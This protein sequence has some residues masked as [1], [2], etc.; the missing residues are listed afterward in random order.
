MRKLWIYIGLALGLLA[1]PA[2]AMAQD[3]TPE[4]APRTSI[5]D[6]VFQSKVGTFIDLAT[7]NPDAADANIQL[8]FRLQLGAD[9]AVNTP[10]KDVFFVGDAAALNPEAVANL[11]SA[12]DGTTALSEAD[13]AGAQMQALFKTVT[14]TDKAADA[15]ERTQT[16]IPSSFL[17]KEEAGFMFLGKS[18]PGFAVSA[19]GGLLF[20]DGGTTDAAG[21]PTLNCPE[22]NDWIKYDKECLAVRPTKVVK[23][24][25]QSSIATPLKGDNAPVI[26][27]AGTDDIGF[28]IWAQFDYKIDGA[29]WLFQIRYYENGHIDYIVG[30][31][32]GKSA[33]TATAD[34]HFGPMAV[35]GTR[36][37]GVIVG[38][39]FPAENAHCWDALRKHSSITYTYQA[40]KI[41]T[42]CGPETG[43]TISVFPPVS[44]AAFSLPGEPTMGVTSLEGKIRLDPSQTSASSLEGVHTFCISM[45]TVQNLGLGSYDFPQTSAPTP[46]FKNDKTSLIYVGKP[47]DM[48][49][50]FEM[51]LTTNGLKPNTSYY[52]YVYSAYYAPGAQ[53]PYTYSEKP[54]QTFGP[55]KTGALSMVEDAK[56]TITDGKVQLTFKPAD[57]LST[58]V[59]KSPNAAPKTP[60]GKLVAGDKIE[61]QDTVVEILSAGVSA[62]EMP[63]DVPDGFFIHLYAVANAGTD[64]ALYAAATSISVYLPIDTLPIEWTLKAASNPGG[65]PLGWSQSVPGAT[66]AYQKAAFAFK[67]IDPTYVS[68][69]P[70]VLT[71]LATE[72]ADGHMAAGLISPVFISPVDKA[73]VTFNVAFYNYIDWDYQARIPQA[74]DSVYIEYRLNGG[75]WQLA[76]AFTEF[77]QADAAGITTL[78]AQL[79]GLQ[80]KRVELRY[81]VHTG[82]T[83]TANAIAS[84]H[85]TEPI[86]CFPPTGLSIDTAGVTDR[87][88]ALRWDDKENTTAAYV[89]AYQETGTSETET[90]TRR[91]ATGKTA[92]LTELNPNTT[93]RIQAQ[94]VCAADDSSAFGPVVPFSTYF[95][96]PYTE[97][98]GDVYHNPTNPS[99][100]IS[101]ADR[102]VRS[103]TGKIGGKLTEA[104]NYETWKTI[105]SLSGRT[106]DQAQAIGTCEDATSAVFVLPQVYTAEPTLLRFTLN[107]FSLT[108][109]ENTIFTL[110]EKGVAPTEANCRLYVAVSDNGAFTMADTVLVLTGA[111]LALKDVAFELN[112]AKT[113]AVQVAFFFENPVEHGDYAFNLEAYDLSLTGVSQEHT[114]SLT[115]NPAEGGT[116][117]GAGKHLEGSDVTIS[118]TPNEGY[119]F[120]A[121]MNGA[122]QLATSATYTFKMPAADASY[123]AVFKSNKPAEEHLLTLTASPAN[124]GRVSGAGSYLA[125]EEV[126]ISAEANDGYVFVAWLSGTDTLSKEAT[127]TFKM[128][129]NDTAFMA[130]FIVK[131]V[132]NENALR[133]NF[134]LSTK[135][136][137]LYIRNL[138]G[139][140]VKNVEVYGLTGN[141]IERFTPN[142]REDLILP[143]KAERAMLFVRIA[144]EKGAAVYKVY[145]H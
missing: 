109:D 111:Q 115:A 3:A 44:A 49:Q 88:I 85:V 54:V 84:V 132:A 64:N 107:S 7:Y 134:S 129:E 125:G 67:Y 97:S 29:R 20:A 139:W 130:R 82:T 93:Y 13:E 46:G 38:T 15:A 78:Y 50:T 51:P 100:Y 110:K 48:T 138:G 1:A 86:T 71:S 63:F 122:T 53:T 5:K 131:P 83:N 118:A 60:S 32:L 45:T 143:V 23:A 2:I 47:T 126:T 28:F 16:A 61:A 121:W 42:D 106:S 69:T 114:L 62:T 9:L 145:V 70:Y 105:Y 136:G 4:P 144:T 17:G 142:S 98:L 73:T 33:A 10:L 113:G 22:A 80:G 65:L 112:V 6:Y 25:D 124:G 101:P 56:A 141:R 123:T 55:Y 34:Y 103:Y 37:E 52:I 36:S 119:D 21:L 26:L 89:I 108:K 30:N 135:D 41:S 120:V 68:P 8:L 92:T 24:T 140:T 127:Y 66:D 76:R 133:A 19:L 91:A 102:G 95:S 79:E 137:S 87:Q 104:D 116:V 12:T 43:R 57:G 90:W 35:Q 18:M 27:A 14:L 31:D 40:P 72:L 11:R 59:V 58:M 94:A 77:P 74:G 75:D 99:D 128:P 39:G 96:T 81:T 117:T